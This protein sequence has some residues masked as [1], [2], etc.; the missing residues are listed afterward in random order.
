MDCELSRLHTT[1]TIFQALSADSTFP[2]VPMNSRHDMDNTIQKC[3]LHQNDML[4]SQVIL[5]VDNLFGLDEKIESTLH[6]E[7][8]SIKDTFLNIGETEKLFLGVHQY[9]S[10][11]ARFLC[12]TEHKSQ[13]LQIIHKFLYDHVINTITDD[14]RMKVSTKEKAP[15]VVVQKGIFDRWVLSV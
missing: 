3:F 1:T 4:T 9:N 5:R 11:R 10:K 15:L 14:S 7:H 8:P 12:K 2:L 6:V 13:C